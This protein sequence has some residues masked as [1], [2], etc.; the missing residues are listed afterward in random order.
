[1]TKLTRQPAPLLEP[2]IFAL[3]D[4]D[5]SE[6]YFSFVWIRAL[7]RLGLATRPPLI[8]GLGSQSRREPGHFDQ[9]LPV[10][11]E[12]SPP[13]RP[14][15]LEE[16]ALATVVSYDEPRADARRDLPPTPMDSYLGK[17]WLFPIVETGRSF[18]PITRT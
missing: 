3:P 4:C 16:H 14:L 18:I 1:M 17:K 12:R 2:A 15:C 13:F 7:A 9:G 6:E 10:S 11:N 8:H 5:D